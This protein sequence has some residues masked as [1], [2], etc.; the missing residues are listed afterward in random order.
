MC[1]DSYTAS[2]I[3]MS[4]QRKGMSWAFKPMLSK[5][6]SRRWYWRKY[7]LQCPENVVWLTGEPVASFF[8]S[9]GW[10]VEDKLPQIFLP[11]KGFQ[12]LSR[13]NVWSEQRRCPCIHQNPLSSLLS[14]LHKNRAFHKHKTVHYFYFC[15]GLRGQ[16]PTFFLVVLKHTFFICICF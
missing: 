2:I 10:E 12:T 16:M 11:E 4:N 9:L 14:C 7:M 3:G 13:D 8:R 1:V 15:S 6:A 5:W